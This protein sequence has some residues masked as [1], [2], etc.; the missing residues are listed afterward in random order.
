MRDPPPALRE[1]TPPAARASWTAALLRLGM[2]SAGV[3]L[4]LTLSGAFGVGGAPVWVKLAYWFGVLMFGSV[5]SV[6]GQRWIE[7]RP[8]ANLPVEIALLVVVLTLA[9][10]PVVFLA[11]RFAFG[12][13]WSWRDLAGF[14]PPV[15]IVS[16]AMT[17]LN[18]LTIRARAQAPAA[19]PLP[20]GPAEPAPVRFR[21]RLPLRLRGAEIH[22]VEAED[23]Y[24]RV[25]TDRGSD[26]LLLR[27]ADAVT[28]LEGIEGAQCH[29][30]W[31]VARAAVVDV[32]RRDGR[33]T[34]TL[35]DGSEA[36]VSRSFAPALR[37]AGWF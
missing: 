10:T 19:Q 37:E 6:G 12:G 20:A 30:S 33:A 7:R 35:K 18:V 4:F 11:T 1:P 5:L 36:P 16:S 32:K 29:R 28:E 15:F 8:D 13:G 26:L 3:A 9:M 23:H 24:L 25:H 14:L 17:T 21:E 2:I 31:W 34:L 27:L 22:A